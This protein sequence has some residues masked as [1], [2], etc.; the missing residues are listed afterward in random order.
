MRQACSAILPM[1]RNAEFTD[2]VAFARGGDHQAG[3]VVE[4]LAGEAAVSCKVDH[5]VLAQQVRGALGGG[6]D[7]R[8]DVGLLDL[9][10]DG[11]GRRLGQRGFS[12]LEG[13]IAR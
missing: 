9:R 1:V 4:F 10:V 6:G 2:A 3:R 12:W 7:L 8:L 5:D 13:G 11:R